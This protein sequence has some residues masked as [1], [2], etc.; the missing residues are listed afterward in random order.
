MTIREYVRK[1]AEFLKITTLHEAW[2]KALA[3]EN[4]NKNFTRSLKTKVKERDGWQCQE[5]GIKARQ[6]RQLHSYLTIHHI[7]FNH[8]DCRMENLI[9]LCPLCHAKTNFVKQ[10]WIRY[11]QEKME[12]NNNVSH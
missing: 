5:C 2:V 12:I 1:F 3:I 4:K 6:L 8:N 11:Y 9:T 10:T 7:N